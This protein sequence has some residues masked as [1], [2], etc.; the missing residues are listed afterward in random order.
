MGLQKGNISLKKLRIPHAAFYNLIAECL[1]TLIPSLSDVTQ[2]QFHLVVPVFRI[3][4]DQF[5]GNPDGIGFSGTHHAAFM[6]LEQL[7]LGK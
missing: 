2:R 4:F 3:L 6:I 5:L 7:I 1:G